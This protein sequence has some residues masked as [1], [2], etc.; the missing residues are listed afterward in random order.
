MAHLEGG[1]H[2]DR[3]A[4]QHAVQHHQ[5]LAHERQANNY[6]CEPKGPD[7]MRAYDDR[8]YIANPN[9]LMQQRHLNLTQRAQVIK[10]K[11]QLPKLSAR[12]IWRVYGEFE[13]KYI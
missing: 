2:E 13:T 8:E 9:T 7:K 12:T 10:E 11:L 5:A 4:T 3:C 6:A 1:I